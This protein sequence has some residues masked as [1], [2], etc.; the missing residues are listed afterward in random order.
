MGHSGNM[1]AA[2]DRFDQLNAGDPHTEWADGE[3]KPREWLYGRRMTETLKA[4]MPEA[5]EALQLTARCQH[6]CRWE[7]PRSR[8]PMDRQGYLQWRQEL[9]KFHADKASEV[10]AAI[11]YGPEMIDRVAFLLQ[12]KRLKRDPE[13]QALE[14]VI[15]LVFLEHYFED[16]AEKH[17]EDKVVDI[18]RKTWRKMS[19]E[20]HRAAMAME[21]SPAVK[22]L[23]EKALDE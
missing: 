3:R 9:K 17:P 20:G 4:Y 10:L 1:H 2:F 14:D 23:L 22:N 6:L 16:F 18:L 12:K 7:I 13:T 15:C 5:S 19:A 11:G 8:Y 21:H